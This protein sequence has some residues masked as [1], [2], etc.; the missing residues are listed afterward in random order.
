MLVNHSLFL[1]Y[2]LVFLV[3]C[4][5]G[6]LVY[7]IDQR[8]PGAQIFASKIILLLIFSDVLNAKWSAQICV[9]VLV[10]KVWMSIAKAKHGRNH[11]FIEL[12]HCLCDLVL[13]HQVFRALKL[14]LLALVAQTLDPLMELI[15]Q[16]WHSFVLFKDFSIVKL[17]LMV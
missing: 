2:L 7:F 11:V 15:G 12:L 16:N 3:K 6:L 13:T 10:A 17:L 1:C 5:D 4:H 8:V 14:V 9:K